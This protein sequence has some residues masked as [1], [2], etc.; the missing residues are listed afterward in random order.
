MVGSYH[1]ISTLKIT[2]LHFLLF[3]DASS[4]ERGIVKGEFEWELGEKPPNP[5][6]G[7]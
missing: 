6:M 7:N 5:V 4:V 1:M 3:L 2:L